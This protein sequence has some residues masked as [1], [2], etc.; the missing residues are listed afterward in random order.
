[1]ALKTRPIECIIKNGVQID[2]AELPFDLLIF[3][4]GIHAQSFLSHI[5]MT[6]K[7]GQNICSDRRHDLRAYQGDGEGFAQLRDVV[8]A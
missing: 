5:E 1:M 3:A 2:N 6:G 4:T 7:S 8:R